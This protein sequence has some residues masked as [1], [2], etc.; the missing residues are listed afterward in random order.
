MQWELERNLNL[1]GH[2]HAELLL[3]S[4][5]IDMLSILDLTC[6]LSYSRQIIIHGISR[7]KPRYW[8]DIFSYVKTTIVTPRISYR[9]SPICLTLLQLSEH[10][11]S[12]WSITTPSPFSNHSHSSLL[13][14]RHWQTLQTKERE[15]PQTKELETD[16]DSHE[17]LHRRSV[18]YCQVRLLGPHWSFLDWGWK[19]RDFW[20]LCMQRYFTSNHVPKLKE[21]DAHRWHGHFRGS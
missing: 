16:S 15:S 3:C 21:V 9:V 19:K 14:L 17:R 5:W 20:L 1:F 8:W 11:T 12:F 18:G 2:V 7:H 10:C 13:D 6:L 4:D